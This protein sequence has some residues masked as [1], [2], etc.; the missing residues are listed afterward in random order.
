MNVPW[1]WKL[2]WY[3]SAIGSLGPA[4]IGIPEPVDGVDACLGYLSRPLRVP[5]SSQCIEGVEAF[6]DIVG[7][8]VLQRAIHPLAV[9][10][11]GKRTAVREE[12]GAGVL[13]DRLLIDWESQGFRRQQRVEVPTGN[14]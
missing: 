4:A 12:R 7:P 6:P 2:T 3:F 10:R 5:K 1:W 11:Q 8:E 13:L 9:Q 14:V